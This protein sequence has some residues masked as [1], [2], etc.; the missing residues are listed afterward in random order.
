M[1]YL[2]S[3]YPNRE[4]I[5]AKVHK[6]RKK[7]FVADVHERVKLFQPYTCKIEKVDGRLVAVD[8]KEAF[9]LSDLFQYKL[10]GEQIIATSIKIHPRIE[11]TVNERDFTV[12]L[13]DEVVAEKVL[14]NFYKMREKMLYSKGKAASQARGFCVEPT[15]SLQF[16]YLIFFEN[17]ER[18]RITLQNE[19]ISSRVDNQHLDQSDRSISD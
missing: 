17:I 3:P 15:F 7:I 6:S 13:F 4:A 10:V 9:T 14:H 2:T 18:M 19:I 12:S 8:M 11:I 5:I 16:N 1:R